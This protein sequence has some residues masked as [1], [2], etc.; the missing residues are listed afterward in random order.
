M[1][2][3]GRKAAPADAKPDRANAWAA[4]DRIRNEISRKVGKLKSDSTAD[5]RADR[6]NDERY[7]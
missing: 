1:G 2:T 3:S 6:D 5:I 7:R 4:V